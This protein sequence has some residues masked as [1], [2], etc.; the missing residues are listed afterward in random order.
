MEDRR[1][2]EGEE[3]AHRTNVNQQLEQAAQKL[4]RTEEMLRHAT[5]DAILGEGPC[6]REAGGVHPIRASPCPHSQ[7]SRT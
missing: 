7:L 5:K 6:A 1:I 2:R 4:K 3:A